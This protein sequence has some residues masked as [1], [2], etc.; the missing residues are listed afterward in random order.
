MG[1]VHLKFDLMRS[2]G[3]MGIWL[4]KPF[5][6]HG[7][8]TEAIARVVEMGWREL[9]LKRIE[10]QIFDGN[11]ASRKAFENNDFRVVAWRP[12]SIL[13]RGAYRDVW[14]LAA[15]PGREL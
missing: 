7:F 8:G 10:A 12:K 11:A 14:V 13:Q 1:M 5:Q 3:E 15:S 4:G 2:W 6:G 9:G